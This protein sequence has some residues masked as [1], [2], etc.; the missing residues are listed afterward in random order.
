MVNSS[1]YAS[2]ISNVLLVNTSNYASNISNVLLNTLK[3]GDISTSNYAS[4]ISN[5]LLININANTNTNSSNYA[6][7][8]SNILL[9][10]INA[11]NNINSSNYASNIS[12]V[13]L[14]NTNAKFLKLDGTNTMT[15]GLNFNNLAQN[16]VISF[17]DAAT[18]NNFQYVGLGASSGLVLSCF[19]TGDTFKFNFG[20]TTTTLKQV[21]TIDGGGSISCTGNIKMGTANSYPDFQLGSTNGNNLGIATGAGAFSTSAGVNDMVLRSLN[22]LI[23]QNGGNDGALIID[24]NNYPGLR[25]IVKFIGNS[26]TDDIAF[27]NDL[28]FNK[29][30]VMAGVWAGDMC[31]TNYWGVSILLNAGGSA[32][33]YGG[34]DAGR[35]Y[36]TGYASFNVLM[37][38]SGSSTFDRRLF[39]IR[40]NGQMMMYNDIWHTGLDN[41]NRF[42]FAANATTF[43]SSGGGATDNGLVVYSSPATG[44]QNNLIIKN[45]GDTTIRGNLSV[46]GEISSPNNSFFGGLRINGG[47]G[48]TLYNYGR[49]LGLLVNST[50]SIN[51]SMWGGNGTIMTINN[52]AATINQNLIVQKDITL[53]GNIRLYANPS[54]GSSGTFST[55]GYIICN[56]YS[57]ANSGTDLLGTYNVPSVN[58]NNLN[59]MIYI[60][61]DTFTGFHRVFTEDIEFDKENPQKFKDD[62]VGRIV[63]STGKIA[64]DTK[65]NDNNNDNIT[66][67][68]IKYDKEGITI[69]DALP[70]VELSRKKK[71][72]RVFGV[73]GMPN[74]NNSRKERLI[75]NSVGEGGIWICNS[76][77]NIEN[78]DYIQSSDHLGYGEKQDEIY[79]CNYTVA[80][81][82][83][84]CNFELDSPL[85]NCIELEDGLR[86]AFI[87]CSYHC[88]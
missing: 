34:N 60:M 83:M 35:T 8:I 77:G 26:S 63:I 75:I 56:M 48:N 37:R 81:A 74:R 4:N 22:K 53:Y 41:I 15:S 76:N 71:D 29:G 55:A 27:V 45:N 19:G 44:S 36:D 24:T 58:S 57:I 2:N 69:E 65:E 47:D 78:G 82:T 6:S 85:Y 18:P 38:N 46:S 50:Q 32:N 13:L 84:D 7:N 40:P 20:L 87:A 10:Y 39:T 86:V 42:Y 17:Y 43:I 67:W 25:R 31:I 5:I 16:K 33:G 61:F 3:S 11:N 49:D 1:N 30:A 70:M 73:M 28:I 79:L 68:E 9:T 64:T 59:K 52:N 80:K 88:A 66:E 23:L 62:Y 54:T 51:F 72:K 21:M 12:N 14:T